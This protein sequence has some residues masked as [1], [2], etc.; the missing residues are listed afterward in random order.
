[1]EN[2]AFSQHRGLS[3]G[4]S[5]SSGQC[6]RDGKEFR[7]SRPSL[8]TVIVKLDA[9]IVGARVNCSFREHLTVLVKFGG[10]TAIHSLAPSGAATL[11]HLFVSNGACRRGLS[12]P[13]YWCDSSFFWAEALFPAFSWQRVERDSEGRESSSLCTAGRLP[14]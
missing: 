7:P 12:F 6:P 14:C 5:V 3:D 13:Q 4:Y 8:P 9:R 2:I 1:M 10:D 11:A